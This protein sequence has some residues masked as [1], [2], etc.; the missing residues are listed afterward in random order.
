MV[1]LTNGENI[2][3]L[4]NV[5]FVFGNLLF[6]FQKIVANFSKYICTNCDG[7]S[8]LQLKIQSNTLLTWIT[9]CKLIVWNCRLMIQKCTFG[10]SKSRLYL[11][12]RC[13]QRLE[14]WKDRVFSYSTPA[15][16]IL[17]NKSQS[18]SHQKKFKIWAYKIRR[19]GLSKNCFLILA[20]L[21]F[22]PN[23][24]KSRNTKKALFYGH[25]EIR[26]EIPTRSKIQPK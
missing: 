9:Q 19:H 13:L 12:M 4:E 16:S 10:I 21:W 17:E 11:S 8:S 1:F 20:S 25:D 2:I 3:K 7:G 15:L 22:W 5:V 26:V 18:P 24:N 23:K 6:Y 14:V